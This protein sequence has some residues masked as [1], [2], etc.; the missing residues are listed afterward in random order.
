MQSLQIRFLFGEVIGKYAVLATPDFNGSP[1]TG[2]GCH[3]TPP[4]TAWHANYGD[5]TLV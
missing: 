3:A 4:A 1:P 2:H 5:V